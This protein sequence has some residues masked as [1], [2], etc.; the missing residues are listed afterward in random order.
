MTKKILKI[1][2]AAIFIF[3]AISIGALVLFPSPWNVKKNRPELQP[4]VIIPRNLSANSKAMNDLAEQQ[5]WEDSS[6]A[7]AGFSDGEIVISVITGYYDGG[8][9]EK[10]FVAYR[11]LLEIESTIYISFIDYDSV[12]H[13]FIRA[14]DGPTG[15]TRPGTVSLYTMDLLGD[16][17]VCVVLQGMNSHG[18]HTLTIYRKNE[19]KGGE[20]FTKIAD[21]RIDGTISIR[22]VERSAAYQS[23][24][25]RG[26]SFSISAYGR[27]Q[28]SN[29]ILDQVEIVYS[30]SEEN[31]VYR[32][33]TR[34]R[35]PGAQVEQRRV[36]ELLGN[37]RL[38]EEFISGLWYFITPQG[39]VNK[40]Q[41]IFFSPSS[42]EIIFFA[43]ETQQVFNWQNSNATRY[44]LYISSQNISVTTLKR[45]IDIE[46]ET[47]ESVRVRVFEDVRL[48]IGVNAPWDGSYKKAGLNE[49]RRPKPKS[50]SSHIDAFYDGSLGKIHFLS[51]G[52]YE[53]NSG[54]NI[55]QGK[56]AFFNLNDKE[57]LEFRSTDHRYDNRADNI[58]PP[59]EIYLVEGENR[60]TLTLI[61]VRIGTN[62]IV[63]LNERAV[64]LTMVS[65]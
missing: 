1:V 32:E 8:F 63:K 56:Y 54:G 45:S 14:W 21:L 9:D 33:R 65:E 59:R 5:A 16:R 46:L 49:N 34:N 17:S 27:D 2:T 18:E 31:G 43:D 23:G 39:N 4:R 53:L 26:Q 60:Q 22:E 35:I 42:R 10:Q 41:F 62:G 3:S 7:K 20:L 58:P 52:S 64:V 48:K 28:E 44:G 13:T 25:G 11:N 12:S 37:P 61:K 6:S 29:N 38:F 55:V 19:P 50:T 36:R 30:Y 47:L 24:T 15:A 51:N 40:N 57:L